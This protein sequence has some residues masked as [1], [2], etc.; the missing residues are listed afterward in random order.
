[1]TLQQY[2]NL[3]VRPRNTDDVEQIRIDNE[4]ANALANAE[5]RIKQ[6]ERLIETK[7]DYK[8][9]WDDLRVPASSVKVTGSLNVP[10]WGSWLGDLQVL[11]FDEGDQIFFVAQLPHAWKEGSAIH[12]HIHWTPEA[13]GSALDT[14]VWNLEYTIANINGTFPT[15]VTITGDKHLGYPDNLVINTHLMTEL[16][17]IE[18]EDKK[19][20]NMLVC[21]LERESSEE[22]VDLAG[23]L[24]V[25][26]HI[27]LDEN[28]SDDEYEKVDLIGPD[29]GTGK[30]W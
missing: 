5:L 25:D 12:P 2:G 8:V 1:M 15:P 22:S 27:Q 7:R 30:A 17:V 29:E 10:T 26:F 24:E 20:S 3:I 16:P 13:N 28:G 9:Q 21:R 23:L 6:L 14:A 18:M 11:W 4:I 19:L